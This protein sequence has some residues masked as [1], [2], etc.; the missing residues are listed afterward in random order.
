[1]AEIN[2]QKRHCQARKEGRRGSQVRLLDLQQV[3]RKGTGVVSP[4]YYSS[5][6]KTHLN[7]EHGIKKLPTPTDEST[8]PS[9]PSASISPVSPVSPVP[10]TASS[11]TPSTPSTLPASST[12]SGRPAAPKVDHREDKELQNLT[13]EAKSK[14]V[15]KYDQMM[16]EESRRV[17]RSR[18]A[19]QKELRKQLQRPPQVLLSDAN[20]EFILGLLEEQHFSLKEFDPEHVLAGDE[21]ESLRKRL[22]E[23]GFPASAV[24][25]SLE[26]GNS[27]DACIDW[28][29]VNLPDH[30]LP[31]QFRATGNQIRM[32]VSTQFSIDNAIASAGFEAQNDASKPFEANLIAVVQSIVPSFQ[33]STE[34]PNMENVEM[35]ISSL[36]LIFNIEGESPKITVLEKENVQCVRFLHPNGSLLF[37]LSP[38][39]GYPSQPPLALLCFPALAAS[40]RRAFTKAIYSQYHTRCEGVLYEILTD[41]DE[42]ISKAKESATEDTKHTVIRREKPVHSPSKPVDSKPHHPRNRVLDKSILFGSPSDRVSEQ[43]ASLPITNY[44]AKVLDMIQHNQ[45][46]IVSGGTGCGKSTQVPQFLMEAFR[47]SDQ[48]DLNIVV[49]E[50]RR[51]SCLGLYLRVIEEQGFVAGNQC[52]VGYQVQGDVKCE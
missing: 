51:V 11:S 5:S 6:L 3:L 13:L 29:C 21:K 38:Q 39:L 48:K 12:A 50:P 4:K 18:I 27:L 26:V 25:A 43:R 40:V 34:T 33:P 37:C 10:Q 30:K 20:Q 32:S 14:F 9:T 8:P 44:K 23:L 19:N 17:A 41:L 52:P 35:E 36:Q 7:K 47:E 31:K 2:G 1:M 16:A 15:S 45:V 28:L 24:D 46:S 49:C 22:C 42:L